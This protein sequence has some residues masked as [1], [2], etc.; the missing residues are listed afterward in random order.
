[1]ITHCFNI[2]IYFAMQLDS[3]LLWG[4]DLVTHINF[5]REFFMGLNHL[6]V[7]PSEVQLY[8]L[9]VPTLDLSHRKDQAGFHSH[10]NTI[11]C[12]HCPFKPTILQHKIKLDQRV[13]ASSQVQYTVNICRPSIP[14]NTRFPRFLLTKLLLLQPLKNELST[15]FYDTATERP[16]PLTQFSSLHTPEAVSYEKWMYN[17]N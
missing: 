2:T 14:S 8:S 6:A 1:M 15:H 11:A 4:G 16:A 10:N 3:W 13:A 9:K 7:L 17:F 5:N 12:C